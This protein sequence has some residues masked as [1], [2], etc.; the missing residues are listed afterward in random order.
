[1]TEVVTSIPRLILSLKRTVDSLD[2]LLD[3]CDSVPKRQTFIR[4]PARPRR[5]SIYPSRRASLPIE[6]IPEETELV[7]YSF[8]DS[9]INQT[10]KLCDQSAENSELVLDIEC[11][12]QDSWEKCYKYGDFST[13]VKLRSVS[14]TCLYVK[15]SNYQNL[16]GTIPMLQLKPLETRFISTLIELNRFTTVSTVL[17]CIKDEIQIWLRTRNLIC[18]EIVWSIDGSN[19]NEPL[20]Q[21]IS[22][23][24]D[25]PIRNAKNRLARLLGVENVRTVRAINYIYDIVKEKSTCGREIGIFREFIPTLMAFIHDNT[26]VVHK[27]HWDFN[28]HSSLPYVKQLL[29]KRPTFRTF[30]VVNLIT[31]SF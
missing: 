14:H 30:I 12:S 23:T 6:V 20:E 13:T 1:M 31:T 7:F 22:L 26:R 25:K 11:E 10:A 15:N 3:C 9:D 8:S 28:Q 21:L 24:V 19:R 5:K 16:I 17:A 27:N 4:V 2:K 29:A 18:C